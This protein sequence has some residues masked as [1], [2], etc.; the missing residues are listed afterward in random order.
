[1]S[2]ALADGM[3]NIIANLTVLY[4]KMHHFHWYVKG[5]NFYVLHEKFEQFY[6]DLAGYIDEIAER[7]LTL[8]EAPVS[9]LEECLRRATVEEAKGDLSEQQMVEE[10]ISDFA[11]VI[12]QLKECLKAAEQEGDDI[13]ND[14]LLS[15]AAQMDKNI[16]MLRAFSGKNA[17]P[18]QKAEP[19]EWLKKRG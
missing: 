5:T 9:T 11:K 19:A 17:V 4:M 12:Q 1:M 16:W 14:L 10:T 3:N 13:T 6:N 2:K 7:L 18:P 8:N 15:I